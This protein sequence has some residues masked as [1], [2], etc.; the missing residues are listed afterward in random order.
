[1]NIVYTESEINKPQSLFEQ[2]QEDIEYIFYKY[3][4]DIVSPS[5]LA[6]IAH[7]VIDKSAFLE[8]F[9]FEGD[10]LMAMKRVYTNSKKQKV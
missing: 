10:I 7:E 3:T 1:M 5:F 9:Y 8:G 6:L 4:G 2:L